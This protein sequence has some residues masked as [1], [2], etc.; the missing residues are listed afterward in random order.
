[1]DHSPKTALDSATTLAR[2][3]SQTVTP[4][5]KRLS[6]RIA[7]VLLDYRPIQEDERGDLQE[8]YN[9]AW[10]LHSDPLV[11]AYFV[12]VRPKQGRGWVV[13][14]LQDDRLFFAHG[15]V[16]V[17]LFDDRPDSPT[18]G[19]MNVFVMSD[20]RRGMLIIP[21][22]VFHALMNIGTDDALF[23][24]MPTRAYNHEDPDKFRLP[25]R[26]DYIPYPFDDD[27]GS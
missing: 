5:G 8:V 14:H 21:R 1:M 12:C 18:R 3:D 7:G 23:F 13:H 26:N 4:E 25:M 15:T 9:P 24:N 27:F 19:M 2:K 20:H 17:A 10:G 11:Y 16:R 6:K 22:G